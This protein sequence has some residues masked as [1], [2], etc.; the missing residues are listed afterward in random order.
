[1]FDDDKEELIIALRN[2][3]GS[4]NSIAEYIDLK[5]I[6]ALRNEKGSYNPRE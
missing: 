1:M 4:Y 6:I 3:K 2:E 5:N